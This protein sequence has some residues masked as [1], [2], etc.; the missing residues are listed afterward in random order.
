MLLFSEFVLLIELDPALL[1]KAP[2][3]P[4]LTVKIIAN[5]P[6]TEKR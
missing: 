2:S 1:L 5:R 6:T 4:T 3:K